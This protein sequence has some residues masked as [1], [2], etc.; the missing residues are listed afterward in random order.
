MIKA[1]LFD[2]DNT[3]YSETNGLEAR[4]LERMNRFV[5]D[6]LMM[7]LD[8]TAVVRRE[9][10]RRYGTTLEWLMAEKGFKDPEAYF[11]AVH[12]EDEIE[13]LAPDPQLKRLLESLPYEKAILTNSPSEHAERVLK[14]LGVEQYFLSI[15]DIRSNG[16]KGKP[17]AEAYFRALEENN[18]DLDTT[19]YVDDLPKYV[20]GYMDLGGKAILKDEANRYEDSGVKRIHALEDLPAIIEVLNANPSSRLAAACSK[21]QE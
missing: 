13:G 17:H 11:R 9:G 6:F 12:P 10:S 1:I 21:N 3:L 8:E 14:A 5:A 20:K 18:F 15:T 4:V 16:L 19:I 2:L 7:P